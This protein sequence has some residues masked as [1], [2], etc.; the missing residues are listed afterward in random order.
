M[1]IGMGVRESDSYKGIIF[2]GKVVDNN[3]PEQLRRVRVHIPEVYG[4]TPPEELPWAFPKCP[5]S[6]TGQ[7][8]TFG[9]YGVLD[10]D[11]EVWVEFQQ[12]DPHFPMVIGVALR[13]DLRKQTELVNYPHRYGLDDSKGNW[14]IVDKLTG[15]V[16][17]GHFSD[18]RVRIEPNGN[19]HITSVA[20]QTI[21]VEQ[22]QETEI[23]GNATVQVKGNVNV[24]VNGN[25]EMK[26]DGAMKANIGQ[27]LQATVGG[28][29]TAQVTGPATI[30]SAVKIS[31]NAPTVSI[32]G[33]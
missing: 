15:D 33:A 29:A 19:L 21:T 20:N 28:S 24:T 26:V 3:D 32:N 17:I 18:T 9:S 30:N 7:S 14:I 13:A 16:E 5:P 31:L 2:Y 1:S 4:D 23:K 25:A 11:S 27:N 12:G 8:S 22:N 10:V 6:G